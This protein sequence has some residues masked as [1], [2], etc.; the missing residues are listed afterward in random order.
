MT[1]DERDRFSESMRVQADVPVASMADFAEADYLPYL[2]GLDV[3]PAQASELLRIVWD[4]MRMCV[5]M[6]LPP[7]SWGQI[8][9]SIF[10]AAARD[11]GDVE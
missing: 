11:S 3:T 9:S 6:D 7:E 10:A 1:M 4:M 8:T 5:E 2:H